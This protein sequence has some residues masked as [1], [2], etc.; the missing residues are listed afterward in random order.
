MKRFALFIFF[1]MT[2]MLLMFIFAEAL[3][4][5]FL[6]EDNYPQQEA[7]PIS[8][9]INTGLLLVDVVLP[10]PSSVVMIVNGALFGVVG[11]GLLSLVG[12]LGGSALG[13]LLGRG[14][15]PLV[16][17]F[18]GETDLARARKFMA[19]WGVLALVASRPV[20]ILAET[21]SIVAGT[22]GIGLRTT[23]LAAALGLTPIVIL[24]A[25]VG[26]T[27]STLES[28][29]LAFGIVMLTASLTWLIGLWFK[30]SPAQGTGGGHE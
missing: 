12:S 21:V 29:L 22:A 13:Y 23:V 8:G 1:V 17:R 9:V 20:P 6:T 2:L 7:S 14:N 3:G 4:I 26:A 28:G 24:Y 27:A 30:R 16:A 15:Q 10:V 25:Y 19:R 18:V 5:P 11:G